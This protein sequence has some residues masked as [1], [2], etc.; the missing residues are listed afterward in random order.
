V[1]IEV[2]K[3]PVITEKNWSV[4]VPNANTFEIVLFWNKTA[5]PGTPGSPVYPSPAVG[6]TGAA[7][8]YGNT[9]VI[10]HTLNFDRVKFREYLHFAYFS[11]WHPASSCRMGPAN[12]SDSVVDTRGRVYNTKG[13]RICDASILPTK[14]D[15]NTMAPIYG[16]AQRLFEL[17][18]SSEYDYYFN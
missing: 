17:V 1:R 13:L 7:N 12:K 10:V 5:R 6:V 4:G 2:K 8:P 16:M 3:L 15:A 14:P 11:G 18:S 9:G